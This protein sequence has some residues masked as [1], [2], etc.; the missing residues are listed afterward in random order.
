VRVLVVEDEALMAEAVATGLRR[1][2]MAVDVALDGDAAAEHLAVHAY[3]VVVLDRDL[4]GRH[5]DEICRDLADVARDALDAAEAGTLRIER[6]LQ[7]APVAGDLVLLDR[8]AANLIENA[9]R[10]N[11]AGGWVRVATAVEDGH[12]VLRVANSGPSIAAADVEGLFEPFRR[13]VRDRT[14]SQRGAGLGLSIVRA[15]ATAHHGT[16]AAEARPEGGLVVT[17]SLPAEPKT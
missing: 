2:G 14:D 13:G 5:G 12:A 7:A 11:I 8:L 4:P 3:D 15:I 9:I 10:Y 17:V 16:A 6:D 1:E